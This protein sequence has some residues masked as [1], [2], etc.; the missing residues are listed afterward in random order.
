MHMPVNVCVSVVSEDCRRCSHPAGFSEAGARPRA[1]GAQRTASNRTELS[2]PGGFTRGKA[3]RPEFR[4]LV[5][6]F[7]G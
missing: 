5:K 4:N 3:T 7:S 1:R 2:K 6:L